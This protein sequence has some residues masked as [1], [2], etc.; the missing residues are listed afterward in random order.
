MPQLICLILGVIALIA[1]LATG[2]IALLI[3]GVVLLAIAGVSVC[4]C[5]DFDCDCDPST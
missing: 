2:N 4:V 3:V 1:A 5:G